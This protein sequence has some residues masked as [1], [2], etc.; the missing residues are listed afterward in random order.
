MKII[1][2]KGAYIVSLFFIVYSIHIAC[3]T[4]EK[5]PQKTAQE[6][7]KEL[8]VS[9]LDDSIF[10]LDSLIN[11]ETK[12][13]LKKHY[14]QARKAFKQAEPILAYKDKNNYKSINAPN[15]LKVDEEGPMGDY[16]TMNPFGFQVLEEHIFNDD[17]DTE[18]VKDVANMTKSRLNLL[19]KNANLGYFKKRHFIWLFQEEVNRIALTGITGFDSPMLQASLKESAWAYETLKKIL[20]INQENFID[21]TLYQS[22]QQEFDRTI[23]H[24]NDGDFDAFDRYDFIKNYTHK[25]LALISQI[26]KD[27]QVEFPFSM[28]I[29]NEATSLFSANTFNLKNYTDLREYPQTKERAKLGKRLFNDKNL[30]SSK[31]MSCQTCHIEKLAFTDGLKK[32]PN[33]KR[34]SPTL[35][36]VALQR[37]FFYDKR[38]GNLEGQITSVIDNSTEFHTDFASLEKTVKENTTYNQDFEKLYNGDVSEKTIRNAITQYVR[39][40]NYFNS[41]F[42][43]NINNLENTLTKQE[44]RGFNLFMGKAACATCHFAPVFNGT[45]PPD[46]MDTEIELLGV[47]KEAVWE[48]AIIDEDLGRYDVY[49]T[50]ERK[51]FFKTPTIRNI[52]L[53]APY[54]HNGVYNTLEEVMK[55]YNVGG[56]A[57]IGIHQDLQTLPPDALD[58]TDQDIADVI[59]FMKTL[60]DENLKQ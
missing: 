19:S 10:Q 25:H 14:K 40:L 36:Y 60:T 13:G 59:A 57:G 39:S 23:Q 22:A 34:N 15:I 54:M 5:Q 48:N 37:G 8:L 31:T 17:I 29:N 46:F 16:R 11:S 12:E 56:G 45:V 50:E 28:A 33:Q 41:K 49:K 21:K 20:E 4:A 38:E 55:F 52:E 47:P 24:L 44:I 30:S 1:F 27:W 35:T 7:T 6:Q 32:S 3:K 43:K 26:A 2:S 53:T 58:L 18:K 51:Y 42:D 9:Y